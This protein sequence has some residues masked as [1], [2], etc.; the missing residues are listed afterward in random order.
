MKMVLGCWGEA[1]RTEALSH[2]AAVKPGSP[3][4]LGEGT[5]GAC[6]VELKFS[7]AALYHL[8]AN[9]VLHSLTSSRTSV[10]TDPEYLFCF[11]AD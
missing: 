1:S 10:R 7:A 5:S 2:E 11:T 4:G 9:R 6:V 3:R 8:K